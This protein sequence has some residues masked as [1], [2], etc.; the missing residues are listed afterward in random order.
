MHAQITA[1]ADMYSFGVLIWEVCT[2]EQPLSRWLRD[3]EPHEA[4]PAVQ[5]L[6]RRCTN[7]DDPDS[8]PSAR[9]VLEVLQKN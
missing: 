6:F 4:P 5:E 7:Q 9:E 2:L 1:K 3:L 8:R